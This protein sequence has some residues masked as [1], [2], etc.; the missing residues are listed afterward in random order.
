MR[1]QALGG[2][3][4]LGIAV[5]VASGPT[6]GVRR[7]DPAPRPERE[8]REIAVLLEQPSVP[9]RPI[10]EVETGAGSLPNLRRWTKRLTVEAAR[11]GGDAV[12]LL[13]EG[14][15]RSLVAQVIVFPE[16]EVADRTDPKS[17][18]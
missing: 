18:I 15:A 12:L 3:G 2:L 1:E 13:S 9:Y 4:R 11:L 8:P 16:D 5:A 7:T 6:I 17:A 14:D 10:A